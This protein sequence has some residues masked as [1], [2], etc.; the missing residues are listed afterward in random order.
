M[1]C[2]VIINIKHGIYKSL[3]KLPK[4]LTLFRMGFFGAFCRL[5]G[6]AKKAPP[7]LKSVTHILQW[8]NLAQLYF[9]QTRSKKCINHVTHHL[10]SAN[11]SIFFTR[12]QQ[13]LLYQEIQIKPS[14][15]YI[16][17]NS[18]TFF[19]VLKNCFNKNGYNFYHFSKNGY[20]SL[21]KMKVFWNKGYDVS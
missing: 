20:S 17:S 7:S 1:Q 19:W 16:I 12:T 15:W 11:I 10:R 13:I 3:H 6:G 5:G 9:T 2:S 18:L 21:L 8:W 4:D 14:F